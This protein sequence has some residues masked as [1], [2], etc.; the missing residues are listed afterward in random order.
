MVASRNRRPDL[1]A[2]VGEFLAA[3]LPPGADLTV[4]LSGGCDSVVLLHLLHGLLPAGRLRAIHVHHG[5]SPMAD[6]WAEHCRQLCHTLAVPL[7]IARVTVSPDGEGLEAAARQARYAAFAAAGAGFMAIAHHGDD[8]AETIL[9]NLARGAGLSGLAGMRGSRRIGGL[10]VLRPLLAI[11]RPVLEAYAT[12]HGLAYVEDESNRDI[13]LSRNYL[14]HALLPGLRARFPGVGEAMG[15]AA[16]HC[17]E[18]LLLLDE[19]AAEDWARVSDGRSACMRQLVGLSET[20]LRNLLRFRLQQLGWPLPDSVRLE[21]FAR[22][23]LAAGPDR[24]PA[25]SLPAGEMRV[26]AR[27][28]HWLSRA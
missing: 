7:H 22:Q 23:L 8:Q 19:L 24:H 21:E 17:A 14:R 9:F 20:R 16:A 6:D 27:R 10:T 26:Q 28:L 2:R 13:S 5:L 12:E 11:S 4:G 18:A 1:A 15:R 25:L 3:H